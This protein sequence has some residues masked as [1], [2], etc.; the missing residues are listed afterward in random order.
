VAAAFAFPPVIGELVLGNVHLVLVGLLAL[1]WVALERSAEGRKP[2]WEWIAGLAVGVAALIKVFPAV[3]LLWFLLARR[4]R[5]AGGVLVGVM[6]AAA[7]LLPVTGIKP[8]LEYPAVLANLSA[9][10]DTRDT[11][12]PTVWISTAMGF[13]VARIAVTAAGLAL[14][15]WSTRGAEPRRSFALAVTISILIAPALYHH[16]LAVLVLPFLLALSAGVPIKWLALAYFLMWGGQQDALA[17]ASWIVNRAM[18]TLGALVL[19][20]SLAFLE[21]RRVGQ[22]PSMALG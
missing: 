6:V 18:P 9:P 2:R 15:A 19:L 5:A 4:W 11:L 7:V 3:L 16:Y 22:A 17:G 12:A 1:A 20:A 21:R 14:L 8:W 10:S 13:T